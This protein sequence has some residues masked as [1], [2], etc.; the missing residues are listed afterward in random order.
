MVAPHSHEHPAR[1]SWLAWRWLV[2]AIV[3]VAFQ[4]VSVMLFE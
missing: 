1:S 2:A 4:V 3:L